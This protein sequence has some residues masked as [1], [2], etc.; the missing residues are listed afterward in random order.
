VTRT[1]RDNERK[2]VRLEM[3]TDEQREK[4]LNYYRE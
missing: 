2:H 4:R 3:E 1:A